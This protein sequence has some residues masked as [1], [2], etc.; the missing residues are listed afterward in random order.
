LAVVVVDADALAPTGCIGCLPA[1]DL[2]LSH[3]GQDM[4]YIIFTSGSSGTPK[5]VMVPNS[6]V[7]RYIASMNEI[8]PLLPTDRV[9]QIM[10]LTFDSSIFD[11]WMGW[12]FGGAV[13]LTTKYQIL[14]GFAQFIQSRNISVIGC[15][16][17]QLGMINPEDVPLL[18]IV[19]IGGEAVPVPLIR[20]W[21]DL[22][23][24]RFFNQYGP[25][26]TT[27]TVTS[28]LCTPD[29]QHPTSIG[30]ANPGSTQLYILD[31]QLQLCPVGVPGELLVGGA[32]LALGYLNQPALTASKFIPN[33]FS[34]GLPADADTRLYKTGDLARWLPD[35]SVEYLGRIDMQVKLRGFCIELE[36]I[37]HHIRAFDGVR[38]CA[39]ILRE[40]KDQ[41]KYLAA[42]VVPL[43]QG[44]VIDFNQLRHALEDKLPHYMIPSVFVALDAIPLTST[45]KADLRKLPEYAIELKVPRKDRPRASSRAD[46]YRA[47]VEAT[48]LPALVMRLFCEVLEVEEVEL[49]SNFFRLGGQ[50]LLASRLLARVLDETSIKVKF[51]MFFADPTPAFLIDF[52]AA[53]RTVVQELLNLKPR[54]R[55]LYEDGVVVSK[56]QRRMWINFLLYPNSS[57]YHVPNVWALRGHLDV[58]KLAH[59]LQSVVSRHEVFKTYIIELES[60]FESTLLQKVPESS[61]FPLDELDL[62]H[63][64]D[65]E[66]CL[67]QAK[68]AINEACERPFSL[69]TFG[70]CMRALLIKIAHEDYRLVINVHHIYRWVFLGFNDSRN[71]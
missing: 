11:L 57:M 1:D 47:V 33:P 69:R 56:A 49:N 64:E 39:V 58:P 68:A 5:G 48:D 67:E 6:S 8:E 22:E 14:E 4:A 51:A 34:V 43:Q 65:S 26:E 46:S 17:T 9:V 63:V 13:V 38:M 40:G 25:T 18:R 41:Q 45:G 62:S 60:A 16:P 55:T 27:C 44:D 23:S 3:V 71:Q 70:W 12:A 19:A 15:T 29:M 7:V 32:Q 35:G 52:I 66:A 59:V 21:S 37:E 36:E 54:D 10:A 61:E 50:S 42:Y 53:E 24:R 20:K 28:L 2:P 30:Y 31:A